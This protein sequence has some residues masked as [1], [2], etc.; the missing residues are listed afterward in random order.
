MATKLWTPAGGIVLNDAYQIM[1]GLRYWDDEIHPCDCET[2][3][4]SSE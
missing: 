4:L 3:T 2:T 1:P